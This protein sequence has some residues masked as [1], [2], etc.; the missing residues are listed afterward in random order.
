MEKLPVFISRQVKRG[1]YYFLDRKSPPRS[2]MSIVCAGREECLNDYLIERSHFHCHAVELIVSGK[3][4]LEMDDCK[5]EIGPGTLFYYGP[6]T[7]YLL[8]ALSPS[9]LVKY[10]VDFSGK[11]ASRIFQKAGLVG[12]NPL[13]VFH[14]RWLQDI[15]DQIIDCAILT[16]PQAR[17]ITPLLADLFL[18]RLNQDAVIDARQ[19]HARES[20]ERCRQYIS[21]NYPGLHGIADIARA[22]NVSSA[23]LS[24]LFQ[25]FAS[26]SPLKFLTRMKMQHAAK[27]IHR[28]N[29]PI[30]VV[31]SMVGFEDPYYFSRVFKRVHGV[32]PSL[33]V[34]V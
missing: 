22:C 33:F 8:R 6:K 29:Y 4:Q 15:F 10:F 31:A 25:R 7:P 11:D 24:R 23:Y 34:R 26:E 17:R 5:T 28:R 30:K 3:W 12:K 9:G 1:D 32:S 21:G 16:E 2:G 19:T 18:A 13:M 27:L 20:Y 14:T